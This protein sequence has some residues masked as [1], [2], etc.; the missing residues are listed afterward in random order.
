MERFAAEVLC[1]NPNDVPRVAEALIAAGCDFEVHHDVI[2]D[3]GPTVYGHAAGET[4]HAEDEIADWLNDIIG[5]LG[6]D[7]DLC[8]YG[9]PD[10]CWREEGGSLPIRH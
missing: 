9:P 6:G 7:V 5:P 8:S 2:D 4:E 10:W 1:L 3:C